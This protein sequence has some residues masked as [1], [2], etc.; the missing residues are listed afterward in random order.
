MS[1]A[2]QAETLSRAARSTGHHLR[3]AGKE[4]GVGEEGEWRREIKL[5]VRGKEGFVR[6][7][8]VGK[9]G[10]GE[11]GG[12]TEPH[13]LRVVETSLPPQLWQILTRGSCWTPPAS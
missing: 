2:F 1:G 8:K 13:L 9:E 6:G 5:N 3:G 4:L 11:E 7:S 10:P 12:C